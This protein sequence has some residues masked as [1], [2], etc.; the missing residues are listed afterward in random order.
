MQWWQFGDL[1]YMADDTPKFERLK[2]IPASEIL[3][4][5]EKGEPVEYENVIIDVDID[6]YKLDLKRVSIRR[7]T[8][9]I[10]HRDHSEEAKLVQ[11]EIKIINSAFKGKLKLNNLLF[12]EFLDFRGTSFEEE[13][14]FRGSQFNREVNFS[15]S[16]FKKAVIFEAIF[17]DNAEFVST[18]FKR[19]VLFESRFYEN[20]SFSNAKFN[21][22]THL[23][24]SEFYGHVYFGEASF[25]GVA[26]FGA[27]YI[28][29]ATFQ[30]AKFVVHADFD[31]AQFGGDV[32]FTNAIFLGNAIFTFAQIG[33]HAYFMGAS[34]KKEFDIRNIRFNN[35]GIRWEAIK[36]HLLCE[37]PEY[38]A[39][40]KNF[41]NWEQFD[42]ADKCYYQYKIKKAQKIKGARKVLDFFLFYFYGYGIR[43]E[44][45]LAVLVV[46]FFISTLVYLLDGQAQ[47][48]ESAADLSIVSLAAQLGNNLTGLS[49]WWSIAERIL[50]WLL[51]S[52]FLVVLAKKTLR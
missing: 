8:F 12:N 23:T 29:G 37:G 2:E 20:V 51:M 21:G 48:I 11:S 45:P 3:A 26:D 32:F 19:G 52:S 44:L 6:I 9:E 13:V 46:I 1:G 35:I 4:K 41:N 22:W 43:P 15:G 28:K 36:D 33:S 25:E 16:K 49:R 38:L 42:D 50:G 5:I 14:Q 40:V 39:L 24:T 31:N 17:N 34:F 18:E 47:T 30:N 10:K 27:N 7:S